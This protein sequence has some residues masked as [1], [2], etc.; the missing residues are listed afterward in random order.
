MQEVLSS[1]LANLIPT[2]K[3]QCGG[4]RGAESAT[5]DRLYDD[6]QRLG[7]DLRDLF[8]TFDCSS[9]LQGDTAL[10]MAPKKSLKRRPED[11]DADS[12][13]SGPSRKAKRPPKMK[14]KKEPTYDTYDDA[15]DGGVE[16]EEKG[17]RYRD[18]DKV[19]QL[20]SLSRKKLTSKMY[21]LSDFTKR[22]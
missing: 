1:P 20:Y 11:A 12:S 19:C 17:E 14:G 2:L 10:I 7:N 4:G 15:L 5:A 16:M 21:R 9:H 6:E 13:S 3:I 18:G 8:E 22:L